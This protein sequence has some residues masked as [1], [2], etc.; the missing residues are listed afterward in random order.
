V[1]HRPTPHALRVALERGKKAKMRRLFLLIPALMMLAVPALGQ[2]PTEKELMGFDSHGNWTR[3]TLTMTAN[4]GGRIEEL[5][6]ITDRNISY[7]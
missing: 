2:E 3:E 4:E 6:R 7:Y 5:T 1:I